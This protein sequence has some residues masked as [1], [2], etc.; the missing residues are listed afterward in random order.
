MLL[1]WRILALFL[2]TETTKACLKTPI[3]EEF[4][5]N[6]SVLIIDNS[7]AR[8]SSHILHNSVF[9][10]STVLRFTPSDHLTHLF[11]IRGVIVD[12]IFILSDDKRWFRVSKK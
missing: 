5:V 10:S 1:S 7:P 4:V 12:V 9:A 11:A 2:L 8:F 6:K 3:R